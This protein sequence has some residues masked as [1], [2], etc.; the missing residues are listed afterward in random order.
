VSGG[1]LLGGGRG[2][3]VGGCVG[4]LGLIWLGL[5]G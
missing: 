2:A 3:F 1:G 4:D 5:A